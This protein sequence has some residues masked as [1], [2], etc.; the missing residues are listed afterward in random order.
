MLQV[1]G[2]PRVRNYN[3]SMNDWFRVRGLPLE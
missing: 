1:L 3:G 2:Y